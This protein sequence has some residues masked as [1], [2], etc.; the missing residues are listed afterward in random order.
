MTE[1]AT[2]LVELLAASLAGC[3]ATEA[4]HHGSLFEALRARIRAILD[5]DSKNWLLRKLAELLN[6][7][8]CLSHWT[9]GTAIL[10]MFLAGPESL[11]RWPVYALAATRV[12]QLLNDWS[13]PFTRS[14][15]GDGSEIL[16]GEEYSLID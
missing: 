3:Q 16:E 2:L 12:A 15:G 8:F 14:P 5:D 6:C 10:V 9:C 11:Y 13:H 4:W 7:P 1:A